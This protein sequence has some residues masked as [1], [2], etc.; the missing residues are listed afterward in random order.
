LKAI[1]IAAGVGSRLGD[2]TKNLPKPLLDVNGKSIL[3]HQIELF[4]KFGIKDIVIV[5]GH[6]KEKFRFRDVKYIHNPNYLNVEQADSLMSA[7]NEIVGDVLVSFGDIIFDELV[8]KQLLQFDGE[9]ILATDQE[10]E[11][12]YQIRTE[13]SAKFS[14][15]VAI[16]NNQIIK[17]FKNS[18][19]F[20]G[21]CDIVEFI[22][23]MKLS[24]IGSRKIIQKY[25][26]LEK[27]HKGKFHYASSFEKA[28][29]ID[30]LE[31]LRLNDMEI[32]TQN[33]NGCWCEIDTKQDLEIAKK[34][35]K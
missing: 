24:E 21:K 13:N 2:L 9:L 6:K 3:E 5:T 10:W 15:F 16:K 30:V 20:L 27:T 25:E 14:D 26:N 35:F 11:E 34:I 7:R 18:E 4:H 17:F 33:V 23:L 19:E 31:E 12:S 28:K 22:G 29:I 32:K 8:L 1:I